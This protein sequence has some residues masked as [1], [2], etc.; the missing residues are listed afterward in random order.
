[1]VSGVLAW[2]LHDAA[3]GVNEFCVPGN[4]V[5][6]ALRATGFS[7]AV[8][9]ARAADYL[10]IPVDDRSLLDRCRKRAFTRNRSWS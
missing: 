3:G 2:I 7:D 4:V 6:T 9:R 5:P 10:N 8:A 1:M